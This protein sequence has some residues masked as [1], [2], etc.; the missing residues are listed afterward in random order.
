MTAK[1]HVMHG[2]DHAPGG[3]DP[4]P[5]L[6]SGGGG[7]GGI[8]FDTYPQSGNWLYVET[9]DDSGSPDGWGIE[10]LS[11]DS[12]GINIQS[13]S[14]AQLVSQNSLDVISHAAAVRLRGQTYARIQAQGTT[15]SYIQMLAPDV[16]LTLGPD[17]QFIID[18][19]LG[20]LVLNYGIV[21]GLDAG[22]LTFSDNLGNPLLQVRAPQSAA[23]PPEF[24]IKT[25]ASW[26][27]D[28]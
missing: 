23:G 4:I 24:H 1:Q 5:G 17:G 13:V 18:S 28:L 14:W 3:A 15:S 10:L 16:G 2:R 22:I 20:N 12:S 11:L 7:G 8:Q 26:V 19:I 9:S 21:S 6:G 25:G 27:A